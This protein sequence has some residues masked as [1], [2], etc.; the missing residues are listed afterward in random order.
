MQ[1]PPPLASCLFCLPSATLS[2]HSLGPVI[3]SSWVLQ[4]FT[5][6]PSSAMRLADPMPPGACGFASCVAPLPGSRH[7]WHRPGAH[8]DARSRLDQGGK[9]RKKEGGRGRVPARLRA[10]ARAAVA[11]PTPSQRAPAQCNSSCAQHCN[12]RCCPPPPPTM[13]CLAGGPELQGWG[14][15][16]AAPPSLSIQNTSACP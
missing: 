16:G 8:A 7:P 5:R 14:G 2:H 11:C 3:S 13:K 15:W 1:R 6:T 4:T 12:P 10:R 9:Q